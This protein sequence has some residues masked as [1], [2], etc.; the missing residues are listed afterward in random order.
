MALGSTRTQK[1]AE[2]TYLQQTENGNIIENGF[3]T[4]VGIRKANIN[5]EQKGSKA[6]NDVL[7]RSLC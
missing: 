1:N 7:G 3:Q 4:N 5:E 2:A 6:A